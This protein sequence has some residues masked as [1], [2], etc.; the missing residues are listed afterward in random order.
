MRTTLPDYPWQK[1]TSDLF[2]IKGAN[3]IVV[4]D[5]FSRYPEVIELKST[6]L[7]AIVEALKSIFSWHGISETVVSDSGSQYTSREFTS[8]AKSYNFCHVTSSPL[9]PQSNGHAERAI[10]TVKKL[11]KVSRDPY[12]VLLNYWT[13]P[14]PWCNLTPAELLMGR[15]I[16]GYLPQVTEKLNPNWSYLYRRISESRWRVQTKTKTG[17]WLQTWSEAFHPS[18]MRHKCGLRWDPNKYQAVLLPLRPRGL[19]LS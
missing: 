14:L 1:V 11:L 17:L 8:F 16:R 9:F 18:Q 10:K 4:V 15:M 19:T 3:Y 2:Q 12:M 5:Y 7:T 13:T 6:T